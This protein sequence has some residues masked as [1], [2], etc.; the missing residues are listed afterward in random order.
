LVKEVKN[1]YKIIYFFTDLLF[2]SLSRQLF[3]GW[4]NIQSWHGMGHFP[5]GWVYC[6]DHFHYR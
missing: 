3:G 6:V 1:E 5:G 4:R 2:D